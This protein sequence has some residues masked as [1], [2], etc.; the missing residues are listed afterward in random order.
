MC[1]LVCLVF[2]CHWSEPSSLHVW[3]LCAL[4]TLVCGQ[5]NELVTLWQYPVNRMM[6]FYRSHQEVKIAV[7]LQKCLTLHVG[8]SEPLTCWGRV[9][10]D[11]KMYRFSC[12]I[13][14]LAVCRHLS[15]HSSWVLMDISSMWRLKSAERVNLWRTGKVLNRV[16]PYFVVALSV[17]AYYAAFCS[18]CFSGRTD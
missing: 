4:V 11:I 17:V 2:F 8:K 13:W 9:A 1:S 12:H 15:M 10:S 7:L 3:P 18:S 16:V 5:Q 14:S 6:N